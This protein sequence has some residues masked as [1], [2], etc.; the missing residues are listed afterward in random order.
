M[1]AKTTTI[2]PRALIPIHYT[3]RLIITG[4]PESGKTTF[5]R[6]YLCS[7]PP[8]LYVIDPLG[9]YGKL[10]PS[11]DV[12]SGAKRWD[13]TADMVQGKSINYREVLENVA[14]QLC[15]V[16][17]TTL[18]IEEAEQFM[19]QGKTFPPWT[20]Y[21]VQ[22]GRNWGVGVWATTRRIQMI[23]KNFFD[24]CQHSFFFKSGHTSRIYIRD[25]IGKDWV[26]KPAYSK[27]NPEKYGINNLP[28]HHCL[29]YCLTD[30]S[31]EIIHLDLP[32]AKTTKIM[33]VP[34]AGELKVA[35]KEVAGKPVENSDSETN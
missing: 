11:G 1:A 24:L 13:G 23:N 27:V 34:P 28:L 16:G 26:D 6:E 35:E 29:H 14:H 25:M 33:Q 7:I 3:N 20:S 30:E 5:L 31:S 10:G 32:K 19:P 18:I 9:Q 2:K 12:F 8:K 22:A 4:L 17:H 15:K 21:L